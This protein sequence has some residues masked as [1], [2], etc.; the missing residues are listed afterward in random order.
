MDIKTLLGEAYMEGMSI[1]DINAALA[2]KT[3]VD[4][5][6]LPKS[7]S[8]ELFDKKV[9]ELS[10]K[11][12]ELDDLKKSNMS[13]EQKMQALID[14]ANLTK[15]TYLK[16]S[17]RLDVEQVLIR[18][19]LEAKDYEN[20]IDTLVS[21][22]AEESKNRASALV[23]LISAQKQQIEENFKK[24]L[25]D[26]LPK[27]PRGKEGDEVEK[28]DFDKMTLTEKMKFKEEYPEEYKQ[29]SGGN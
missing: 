18:G 26:N 6:T 12:K 15:S 13:D 9:S 25:R 29:F 28:E 19:G 3:F 11:T 4:P 7:V 2:D 22:D 10:K 23:D 14:E 8:K 20:I 16:K 1:D 5:A 24:N 27:P 17:A 21:E